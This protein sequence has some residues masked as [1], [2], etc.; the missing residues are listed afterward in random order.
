MKH[1]GTTEIPDF[2][3]DSSSSLLVQSSLSDFSSVGSSAVHSQLESALEGSLSSESIAKFLDRFVQFPNLPRVAGVQVLKALATGQSSS[4]PPASSAAS[5]SRSA[6]FA[7]GAADQRRFD[8]ALAQL[9]DTPQAERAEPFQAVIF[10]LP[11]GGPDF[12]GETLYLVDNSADLFE[13]AGMTSSAALAAQLAAKSASFDR[14]TG[15]VGFTGP[16]ICLASPGARTVV[17]NFPRGETGSALSTVLR[18][19]RRGAGSQSSTAPLSFVTINYCPESELLQVVALVLAPEEE[20]H[21]AECLAQRLFADLLEAYSLPGQG[22]VAEAVAEGLL[23]VRAGLLAHSVSLFSEYFAPAGQALDAPA[24]ALD[25]SVATLGQEAQMLEQAAQQLA[26][27]LH[28]TEHGSKHGT[29]APPPRSHGS[30]TYASGRGSFAEPPTLVVPVSGASPGGSPGQPVSLRVLA[31]A[32]LPAGSAARATGASTS[33]SA[34]S[35]AT[36]HFCASVVTSNFAASHGPSALFWHLDAERLLP[37]GADSGPALPRPEILVMVAGAGLRGFHVRMRTVSRGGLRF[38]RPSA[39]A[40]RSLLREVHQLASTQE[41][42]NKDIPEGGAKGGFTVDGFPAEGGTVPPLQARGAF[43]R[44]FDALLDQTLL[45]NPAGEEIL[46]FAGPDEG[47]AGFMAWAPE[48]GRRRGTGAWRGLATGKPPA[49]GGVPHDAHG[50]TTSSVRQ[51]SLGI[52]RRLGLATRDVPTSQTGGPDGDLG[53]NEIRQA[54]AAG[55]PIRAVVDATGVL[56]DPAGLQHEELLRLARLRAPLAAFRPDLL[57]PDGFQV[58]A[59]GSPG[60]PITLPDGR[61]VD[62]PQRFRD[63]FH[64]DPALTSDLFVPCGGR[65]AAV[66]RDN[67]HRMFAGPAAEAAAALAKGQQPPPPPA[68]GADLGQPRFKYIVEGANLFM[69]QEARLFLEDKGIIVFKD[70]SANKGGVTS[71]SLEVLSGLALNDEEFVRLM[72][73]PASSGPKVR[74]LDLAQIGPDTDD[75]EDRLHGF[76]AGA[77]AFYRAY[78]ADILAIVRYN[79]RSEFDRLWDEHQRTGEAISILSDRLSRAILTLNARLAEGAEADAAVAEALARAAG[80][81]PT[82]AATS[83]ES[84]IWADEALRGAALRWSCPP[85]LLRQVGGVQALLERV[86]ETY[87]RAMVHSRLASGFIYEVGLGEEAAAPGAF[88]AFAKSVIDRLPN[89][90]APS[91]VAEPSAPAHL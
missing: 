81:K 2:A 24:Q 72:C 88:A 48:H 23:S 41:L 32:A 10:N 27:R 61:T 38:I 31:G 44:Y 55:H 12:H 75:P 64:L 67:V 39:T 11:P 78:V 53:S 46:L 68:A 43:R 84:R 22:P 80:K 28:G 33:G 36:E 3:G 49:M 52:C 60:S 5:G 26:G 65:P 58:L 18:L 83:G 1:T 29:S 87:L 66:N 40:V 51:Y 42:K 74:P 47:T 77:P 73:S 21:T 25:L 86:P 37:A 13:C 89:D 57:G 4:E 9:I 35:R 16:S 91:F 50:M 8:Q 20:P 7:R 6:Y 62:N 76:P 15:L 70:S 14:G 90:N 34:L 59:T 79:A 17:L 54:V 71:S 82:P 69:T 45:P 30:H 19:L 63:Q 85:S 56:F